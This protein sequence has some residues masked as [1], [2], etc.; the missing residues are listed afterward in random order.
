MQTVA[1]SGA[2]AAQSTTTDRGVSSMKSE[3]FFKLLVSELKQQDPLQPAKTAD[4]IGQVSQIRSIELSKNLT[5]AL[6]QMTQQQR[7]AGAADLLGKYVTATLHAADGTTSDVS[8]IVTG[9]RFESDGTA[10]L[11]LDTGQTV[12]A[13][14]VTLITS[15][16]AAERAKAAAT[17]TGVNNTA[18]TTTT[19]DEANK[20]A[21]TAKSTS[22]GLLP[23]LTMDGSFHL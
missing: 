7:T 10:V 12:S 16:E 4:M 3:D 15:A 13:A 5:D 11:E 14:D 18:A 9:V 20:T 8:G 17:A 6:S 21:Q 23:F 2:P 19:T 22:G 1:V